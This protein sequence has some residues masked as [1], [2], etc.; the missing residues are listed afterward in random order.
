MTMTYVLFYND[1][2]FGY[3]YNR[4]YAIA[5]ALFMSRDNDARYEVRSS[6]LR[7]TLDMG[8]QVCWMPQ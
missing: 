1:E 2:P 6:P 5:I 7:L 4:D 3:T 8:V